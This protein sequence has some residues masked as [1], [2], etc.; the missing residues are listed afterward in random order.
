MD[1]KKKVQSPSSMKAA[2]MTKESFRQT[3]SLSEKILLNE[4]MFSHC[5]DD[6]D[7]RKITRARIENMLYANSLQQSEAP[8]NI[9][10]GRQ[11]INQWIWENK[12]M[13]DIPT[14][15]LKDYLHHKMTNDALIFYK[16]YIMVREFAQKVAA[17]LKVPANQIMDNQLLNDEILTYLSTSFTTTAVKQKLI[18]FLVKNARLYQQDSRFEAEKDT[19]MF[20]PLKHPNKKTVHPKVEAYLNQLTKEGKTE[21]TRMRVLTHINTL[22]T[23]LSNSMQDF[24]ALEAHT[25]PILS[26][27][28]MHLLEF[29]SF[30][31]KKQRKGEYSPITISE[32]I[33]AV[34]SF[35]LFLKKTY[36][37]PNPS[38]K[39]KSIKAPR[40]RF[41]DLPT[42]EQINSFFEVIETYA[43]DPLLERTAF[44]FMLTLGLRSM[45]VSQISWKDINMDIRTICIHSKG[46]KYHELP[47]A[48]K[49]YR[50]LEMLRGISSPSK[51]LFGD[52]SKKLLRKLQSNYKLYSLI[53][54]WT[55]PGGLHL[56]RH[57]FV[58][59]LA[60]QN[61]PPQVLQALSRVVKMDTVSLYTHLNQKTNWL[62]QEINKL[63]YSYQGDK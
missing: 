45:E 20:S 28:E 8:V 12:V 59:N 42:A 15:V 3:A 63:N 2:E 31:L 13:I 48:G 49:L 39:I 40:Y 37:F 33:Y 6:H 60:A 47:L 26:I 55:F 10:I 4:G 29:R 32:C 1:K 56:F 18:S 43:E 44:Q 61:P 25:I 5:G 23:W 53:A 34:K 21:L 9:H 11:G 50:D 51:Y 57:C 17:Y 27:K 19:P 16:E 58:T 46:G 24:A 14:D 7:I 36:G 41:R 52:D 30:L 22:L 54:G 62:S 35:F 38:R